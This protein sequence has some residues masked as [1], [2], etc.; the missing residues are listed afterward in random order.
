MCHEVERLPV[1]PENI[2]SVQILGEAGEV[3]R[4]E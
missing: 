2:L 3:V 1:W 4:E